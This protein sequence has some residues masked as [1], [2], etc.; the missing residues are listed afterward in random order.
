MQK[1][2]TNSVTAAL[3]LQQGSKQ[4]L[5]QKYVAMLRPVRNLEH[6]IMGRA[7]TVVQRDL[8]DAADPDWHASRESR[9]VKHVMFDEADQRTYYVY[10]PNDGQGMMETVVSTLPELF[11]PTGD[12]EVLESYGYPIAL[13]DE[14]M[15]ALV[16]YIL[17]RAYSKDAQNAGA[18]SRAAL[19]YQQYGNQL[20]IKLS[21]EVNTSPNIKAGVGYAAGGVQ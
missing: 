7:V 9:V 4:Q 21:I 11:S 8:M 5:D 15:S 14:Y 2:S 12:P 6:G 20:G 3:E 1:P 18:A 13:R 17:Y 16:D 19:H 10:P